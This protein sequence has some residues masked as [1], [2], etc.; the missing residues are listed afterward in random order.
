MVGSANCGLANYT[1]IEPSAV[2]NKV[3]AITVHD[4]HCVQEV[5]TTHQVV[6]AALPQNAPY[7]GCLYQMRVSY[8]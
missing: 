6:L 5:T 2:S 4:S 1:R 8:H 3:Y 7:L